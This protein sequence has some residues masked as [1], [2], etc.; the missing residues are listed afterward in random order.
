MLLDEDG[1][2]INKHICLGYY[3]K[4]V[5][6]SEQL[7]SIFNNSRITEIIQCIKEK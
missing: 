2:L 7:F 1:Y 4:E 5:F 6:N 3:L